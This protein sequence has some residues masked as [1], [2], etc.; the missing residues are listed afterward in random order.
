MTNPYP[1]LVETPDA[2]LAKGTPAQGLALEP[3]AG[4]RW[5][6]S[7]AY[8]RPDTVFWRF[9]NGSIEEVCGQWAT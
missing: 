5:D 1:L 7:D 2:T 9:A 6:R 8:P 3:L 4:E